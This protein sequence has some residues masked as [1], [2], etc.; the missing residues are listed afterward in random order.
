VVG[1]SGMRGIVSLAAALSIPLLLSPGVPFPHR[2]LIIFI[3]YCVIVIT[4]IVPTL[5][6][7]I[8]LKF[9]HL[10]DEEDEIKQE[11][12]ARVRASENSIEYIQVLA[13]REKIPHELV[14]DFRKQL[15]RRRQIINT[16][17]NEKPYSTLT[18]EYMALKKL[19]FAAIESERK[20]LLELRKSGEI[21]DEV[22]HR[23]S[24][25]L[26]IEEMRAKTLRI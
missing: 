16:Q 5:S 18:D 21:H 12:I 15:D 14:N 9:L 24:D 22:F 7:P 6:L 4:L 13:K 3:T 10:P 20:T 19:I 11:A 25:E 23:L 2:D 1:W 17:L 26:D 8:I